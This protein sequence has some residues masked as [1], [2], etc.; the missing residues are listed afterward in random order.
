MIIVAA[1]SVL[2][3]LARRSDALTQWLFPA[4]I[5][6]AWEALSLA[7]FIPLRVLPAPTAVTCRRM[8]LTLSGE[9]LRNIWLNSWRAIAGLAIAFALGLANGRVHYRLVAAEI[10]SETS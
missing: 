6:V 10:Y 9:L 1:M 3:A 7:G 5:L 4:G 8:E 2:S